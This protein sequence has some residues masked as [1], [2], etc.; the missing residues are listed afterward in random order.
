MPSFGLSMVKEFLNHVT[1]PEHDFKR[2]G[3]YS[4]LISLPVPFFFLVILCLHIS[5][6]GLQVI[7]S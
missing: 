3:E 7:T 5:K 1:S 6:P 2:K 4:C